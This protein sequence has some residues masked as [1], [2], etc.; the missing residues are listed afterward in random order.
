VTEFDAFA[1]EFVARGL[2]VVVKGGRY[3]V[4]SPGHEATHWL[5]AYQGW[6][7][8]NRVEVVA[9]VIKLGVHV[10]PERHPDAPPECNGTR[11]CWCQGLAI[12]PPGFEAFTRFRGCHWQGEVDGRRLSMLRET[13]RSAPGE[14]PGELGEAA[15]EHRRQG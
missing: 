7:R 15:V 6:M 9:A 14:W 2:S 10:P 5:S 11:C 12:V 13:D 1:R 8:D 4:L 3:A